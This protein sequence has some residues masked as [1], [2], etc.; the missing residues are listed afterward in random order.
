MSTCVVSMT[1]LNIFIKSVH[2][3]PTDEVDFVAHAIY[4]LSI[5]IE[6]NFQ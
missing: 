5:D 3:N 4:K 2:M 6:S 1:V